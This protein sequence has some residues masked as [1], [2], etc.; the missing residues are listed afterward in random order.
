MK[1]RDLIEI[2][3]AGPYCPLGGFHVDPWQPVEKAVITHG[4]ADHARWGCAGYLASEA[5]GEILKRRLGPDIPLRVSPF[6][7]KI[8]ANGVQVSLHP[9][10]HILGSGQVRI[11]A[12]GEVWVISGDF[13]VEEDKSCESFELVPCHT[14]V[15]ESTFGLPVFQWEPQQDIYRDINAWWKANA[16]ERKTT[17]MFAY[18][19]GK[20]QRLLVGLD[21]SIGPIFTHGAVEKMTQCY[22]K[23]GV[24]LPRTQSVAGATNKKV[25]KGALILAPPSANTPLW[26]KKFKDMT[27]AFV[28]G[29]MRIRGHRRRRAV[30]RGF[31]LSDHADWKGLTDI[32]LGTGAETVWVT[33][34]YSSEL[35]RWVE[36]QGLRAKALSTQYVDEMQV[37]VEDD[38]S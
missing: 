24:H 23:L 27:S 25:F 16:G 30:D 29:W 32:I 33:H 4:H 26:T 37:E 12:G 11:E 31:A 17:I 18:A 6:G 7:E 1:S 21:P 15:T 10:G 9:A 22:R 3:P 5:T 14:F 2:T 28:S 8:S 38:R 34:G 19:L 20:A 36:D 13:K 35:A